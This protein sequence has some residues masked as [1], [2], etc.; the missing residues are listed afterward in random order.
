MARHATMTSPPMGLFSLDLIAAE[1]GPFPGAFL[2][3]SLRFW[4]LF[5][6]LANLKLIPNMLHLCMMSSVLLNLPLESQLVQVCIV[7]LHFSSLGLQM[8]P[9]V[10]LLSFWDQMD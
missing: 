8:L 9:H 10:S 1:I 6:S 4:E 2:I 7:G 5:S 3:I